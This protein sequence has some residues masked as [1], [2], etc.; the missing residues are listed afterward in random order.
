MYVMIA[1][2][3]MVFTGISLYFVHVYFGVIFWICFEL[4][5]CQLRYIIIII[6]YIYIYIYIIY[7]CIT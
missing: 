7:D 4:T 2:L 1:F 3:F 6:I 5:I